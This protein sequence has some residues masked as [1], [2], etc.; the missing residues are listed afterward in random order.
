MTV[1]SSNAY[2]IPDLLLEL[3]ELRDPLLL[4]PDVGL[5]A[6]ALHGAA[7]HLLLAV[8]L[9]QEAG[10]AALLGAAERDHVVEDHLRPRSRDEGGPLASEEAPPALQHHVAALAEAEGV[11]GA[12]LRALGPGPGRGAE[13]CG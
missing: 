8:L 12:A 3:P 1:F 4:E 11:A 9:E 6:A 10:L 13:Q 7:D 2:I 5:L